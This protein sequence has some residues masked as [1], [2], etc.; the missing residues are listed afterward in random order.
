MDSGEWRI[1]GGA[2]LV[3]FQ[4]SFHRELMEKKER[5]S[6]DLKYRTL[7]WFNLLGPVWCRV[8]I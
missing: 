2:G 1:F 5:R 3:N 7:K 4:T 6:L 8:H